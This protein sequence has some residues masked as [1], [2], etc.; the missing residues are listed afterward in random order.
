VAIIEQGALLAVG[1]V[2]EILAGEHRSESSSE[3]SQESRT[4]AGLLAV[5]VLDN[6]ADLKQWLEQE[7]SISVRV[8]GN[9]LQFPFNGSFAEQSELLKKLVEKGFPIVSFANKQ[10]SLEDAF[11]HV[12]RGRV[13]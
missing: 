10:R 1:S 2:E 5:Q 3:E 6:V 9:S 8:S 12:T 7:L 13:Q 11:L 4:D